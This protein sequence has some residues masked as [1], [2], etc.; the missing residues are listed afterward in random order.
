M[1]RVLVQQ[2]RRIRRRRIGA[3]E[4]SPDRSGLTIRQ[5][6]RVSLAWNRLLSYRRRSTASARCAMRREL[7]SA[8][9]RQRVGACRSAD[10]PQ[11]S[12]AHRLVIPSPATGRCPAALVIDLTGHEAKAVHELY[13]GTGEVSTMQLNCRPAC[14]LPR[15]FRQPSRP[16]DGPGARSAPSRPCQPAKGINRVSTGPWLVKWQRF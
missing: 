12:L 10:R 11:R 14:G 7:Q 6:G 2:T 4:P 16:H 3:G 1:N 13:R 15:Q 9:G 8:A 5:S